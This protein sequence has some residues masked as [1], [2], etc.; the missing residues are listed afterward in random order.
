MDK[1]FKPIGDWDD[2]MS[3]C[4]S[5][6]YLNFRYARRSYQLYLRWRWEDPWEAYL[7]GRCFPL[8]R[9]NMPFFAHDEVA[10]AKPA[11]I[12]SAIDVIK[13]RRTT[14]DLNMY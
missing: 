4:P 3:F 2:S 1:K 13:T 9:L 6:C 12:N 10:L 11:A 5:Q 7:E 8:V 14:W